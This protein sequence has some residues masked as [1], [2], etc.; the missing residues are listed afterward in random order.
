MQLVDH[1]AGDYRFLPGIAPY[2]CGVVAK[3][4]Y[5]IVQVTLAQPLPYLEGFKRITHVLSLQQRERTALC[6]VSLRSPKPFTFAGFAEF[7]ALYAAVLKHWGLF[8]DGVNPVART[9]V[10][11][12]VGAP[13]EPVLYGFS[14]TR[15]AAGPQRPLAETPKDLEDSL[16]KLPI[17][18]NNK[19]FLREVIA[20]YER[21][22]AQHERELALPPT[23]IVAGAGELPEGKLARPDIVSLGDV[24]PVG[25]ATKARYVMDLMESRLHG[26]GVDWP[27]VSEINIYTAHPLTQILPDIVLKRAGATAIHG[28]HW[29]FSRPPIEDIEYEMDLRGVRTELRI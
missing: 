11:P 1:P 10:A 12:V 28:A 24:S 9:N 23:F 27:A 8:V 14:F 13:T 26:L 6:G 16:D 18:E 22:R 15:P 19:A 4:G 2:S 20:Q 5:E 25:L 17:P 29:H 21:E 7:N 3:P